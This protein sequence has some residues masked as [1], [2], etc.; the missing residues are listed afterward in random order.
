MI[1]IQFEPGEEF[2]WREKNYTVKKL[3]GSGMTANVYLASMGDEQEVAIKV[4]KPGVSKDI[5]DIFI[6][7]PENLGRVKSAWQEVYP[8]DP[9][10]IPEFYGAE[11]DSETPFIVMEL[12]QGKKLAD[13]SEESLGLKE[14]KAYWIGLQIGKLL[15]LLHEK[16]G[17]CYTDI[18]LDNFWLVDNPGNSEKPFLKITDW[19]IL[20]ELSDEG[21]QRDLFFASLIM[22]HTL[23]GSM[24]EYARNQL[25]TSLEDAKK[26]NELCSRTKEFLNRALSRNIARRYQKSRDWFSEVQKLHRLWSSSGVSLLDEAVEAWDQMQ[27]SLAKNLHDAAAKNYQNAKAC[28]EIAGDKGVYSDVWKDYW[29]R[30]QRHEAEQ[31]YLGRGKTQYLGSGFEQAVEYFL[32]GADLYPSQSEVLWRWA[33]LA[34]AAFSV[35]VDDFRPVRADA[36]QGLEEL[37]AGNSN[38]AFNTFSRVAEMLTAKNIQIPDGLRFLASEA[39]ILNLVNEASDLRNIG[40]YDDAIELIK[41]AANLYGKLPNDPPI[42]W[43]DVYGD[44]NK[45][46]DDVEKEKRTLG[47]SNE[48]LR[49]AQESQSNKDIVA[50][51][52]EFHHA[53][54]KAPDSRSAMLAWKDAITTLLREGDH[55]SAAI[56]AQKAYGTHAMDELVELISVSVDLLSLEQKAANPKECHFQEACEAFQ[57]KYGYLEFGQGNSLKN[58]MQLAFK[59]TLISRDY[60]LA[61]SL[62]NR[63]GVIW[64]D[65]K[66]EVRERLDVEIEQTT[67][68]LLKTSLNS[69][70][71]AAM[72]RFELKEA[73]FAAY[74]IVDELQALLDKSVD[75]IQDPAR[76]NMLEGIR[77]KFRTI[78]AALEKPMVFHKLMKENNRQA[79]EQRIQQIEQEISLMRDAS[80]EVPMPMERRLARAMALLAEWEVL[81]SEKEEAFLDARDKILSDVARFG[82]SSWKAIIEL[83]NHLL[84]GG[85]ADEAEFLLDDLDMI[86]NG[87]FSEMDTA[88]QDVRKKLENVRGFI[89]VFIQSEDD[90]LIINRGNK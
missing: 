56:L 49:K 7:E 19:S 67:D 51:A 52:A 29:Q 69:M 32:E 23:T 28:L 78:K 20:A 45:L 54:S 77:E 30:V 34:K 42:H 68:L 9:L 8:Q 14:D 65:L 73:R 55:H 31:S 12:I 89:K 40:K 17:R 36:M 11:M 63:M 82:N 18:K 46:L 61:D 70:Q 43:V 62:A 33:W 84:I 75:Q 80:K 41:K 4:L 85:F 83:A 35:G 50:A 86:T 10:I 71:N 27:S 57:E 15:T 88:Y 81:G 22:N 76:V 2:H 87:K 26:F 39:Q 38:A 13:V 24:P 1:S 90:T 64:P 58:I 3:L 53:Y 5:R 47:E 66:E 79:R 74:Q 48:L 44:I 72:T 60:V 6:K 21:V 37:L 16:T 25:S 59:N